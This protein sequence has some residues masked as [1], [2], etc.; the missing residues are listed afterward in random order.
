MKN[1]TKEEL[2]EMLAE[3]DRQ[4]S[5]IQAEL[6]AMRE[7]TIDL[8]DELGVAKREIE[9]TKD[10]YLAIKNN[11]FWKIT[12]PARIA[13]D[14]I[15]NPKHINSGL[16]LAGKTFASIRESGV[17]V[18]YSKIRRRLVNAPSYN[19][20]MKANKITE[21][22]LEAQ[23]Q[24]KFDKDIVFS[25]TVPLYNTPEE[26]LKEMIDSVI[27]QT[28]SGW[29]LCLADGSDSL[30]EEVRTI[31]EDYASRD[32]RI[33]YKKLKKNLGI[34]E[35]TNACLEM[36]TGDYIALFDHD[37]IL[38]PSALYE[39]MRVICEKD[40]D[41][42]YTDEATFISPDTDKIKI[43]HFK[44]DF[45][46]DNLRANNYIC[47]FTSFRRSLLE[48]VGKFKS[49]YDG[50]QDHDMML[51]LTEAAEI[52]E[53]IPKVLYLWR[54]HPE[55]VALSSSS[56]DYAAEAGKKAVRDSIE[57]MG[58]K[59]RVEST[60][61]LSSIYRIRY[62]IAG[63]PKISIVI[64]NYDHIDELDNCLNSIRQKSSYTNYEIII[65]E[66][67]SREQ[68]TFDYY[69]AAEKKYDNVKVLYWPDE[70]NYSAINNYGV[71]EA[72][73]GEYILLLNNDT[74][75]ITQDWIQEMLMYAQRK[76]VGAVGAKLCYPDNTIQHGGVLLGRGGVANH[77]FAGLP[78]SDVGYMGRM[79]YAQNL[80]AVTG[81]CM[82][83]RREVWDEVN[84]MEE[85][86]PVAFN[87]IDFCMRIRKAG[88]LVVWT[89]YAE[90][91]HYESKSRG[92]DD[93][94]PEKK[95]RL[96]KEQQWFEERW[97]EELEKGDP[98]FNPNFSLD[99][100]HKDFSL[101]PEAMRETM[102]RKKMMKRHQ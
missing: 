89:P 10:K 55:S 13:A 16:Q 31:C 65:V 66:N 96:L 2:K 73:T 29:E 93:E 47:H 53:H 25:I 68:A 5:E 3:R 6:L 27:A 52:I 42:I 57:R 20:W 8:Q 58:L 83:V 56:K 46:P 84:G 14:E 44:P 70:F 99:I 48:K 43:I 61:A 37:D 21:E 63:N 75:V 54:A 30:H 33:K 94:A 28:Y 34:S 1:F 64:P 41:L 74:E 79:C 72:A 97:A 18:T 76:D 17:A 100:R 32:N 40:A 11:V 88:Y 9:V 78:R 38:H 67:N 87:D 39:M 50:S 81:A 59:A 7:K 4:L 62:E 22:E 69:K 90:L 95:A 12:K 45:A 23:R 77:M 86:L 80:S 82:M 26:F 92:K 91:Y 71:R 51:R 85:S 36:A 35:N 24:T 98:Y 15:K 19:R 102:K 101:D 49:E 60:K